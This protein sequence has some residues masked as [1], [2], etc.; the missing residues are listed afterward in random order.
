MKT[1]AITIMFKL[2]ERWEFWRNIKG[3]QWPKIVAEYE[4]YIRKR[5]AEDKCEILP[6]ALELG[7]MLSAGGHD[8]NELFAAAVEIIKREDGTLPNN[9]SETGRHE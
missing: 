4:T 5:M 7:R 8:P 1:Q 9:K 6:A 3:D 2:E